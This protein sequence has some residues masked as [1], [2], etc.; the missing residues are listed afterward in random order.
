MASSNLPNNMEVDENNNDENAVNYN[1]LV[2]VLPLDYKYEVHKCICDRP[3]KV[4][5]CGNCH[6]Y[7][8]GRIRLQCKVHPQDVFLM[9]FQTCPYCF[10]AAVYAKESVLTWSQIREMEEAKLPNDSDDF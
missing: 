4:F 1:K 7:F 10:A 2:Y 9:D 3:Q 5:E 8:R 6:H